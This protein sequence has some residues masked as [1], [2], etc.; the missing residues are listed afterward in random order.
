[1]MRKQHWARFWICTSMSVLCLAWMFSQAASLQALDE[2]GV[3]SPPNQ[4]P[5]EAALDQPPPNL[6]QPEVLTKGPLHEAFAA[7][8][9]LDTE[10]RPKV[11]RRPPPNVEEI[12]PE[13]KP[14]GDNVVWVPGYWGW[15][16]DR[17]DYV[18]VSGCWRAIP[19]GRKWVAGYWHQLSDGQ[20]QWVSGYWANLNQQQTEYLPAPPESLEMGPNIAAP[21]DEQFWVP[22]CWVYRNSRYLWRPGYWTG[23]QAGWVWNPA[24]YVW[25]PA[26]YIYVDGFWD[27]S[28][29]RRG[30]A[31]APCYFGGWSWG[32]GAWGWRFGLGLSYQ[33]WVCLDSD[34][35]TDSLFCRIGFGGYYFGDY[36][37]LRWWNYGYRP[38]FGCYGYRLYCPLYNYHQCFYQNRNPQWRN[39]LRQTYDRRI[40]HPENR[41]PTTFRDQQ[42]RNRDLTRPTSAKLEPQQSRQLPTA[43]PDVAKPV[44]RFVKQNEAAKDSVQSFQKLDRQR[45]QEFVKHSRGLDSTVNERRNIERGLSQQRQVD[46]PKGNNPPPAPKVLTAATPKSTFVG[47]P[48]NL[49]TPSVELPHRSPTI[50]RSERVL[51][52]GNAGPGSGMRVSQTPPPVAAP[53]TSRTF[54][55]TTPNNQPLDM[56]RSMQRLPASGSSPTIQRFPSQGSSMP[57]Q[58]FPTS[59]GFGGGQGYIPRSGF[60]PPPSSGRGFP[61]SGGFQ[62][63]GFNPPSG[64][65]PTPPPSRGGG[66]PGR[67]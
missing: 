36:Y 27:Y 28:L 7:P 15:D 42:R 12:P 21:D 66:R 32:L 62:Q 9:P 67:G 50:N 20:Y 65:A 31:F 58:R 51:S 18:W 63:R 60:Q 56:T 13:Q 14:A 44:N 10:E 29:R 54:R 47:K 46:L 38:W 43:N 61:S 6:I 40:D 64:P 8:T 23:W 19:P 34:Y 16:L 53:S 35:L 2:V 24:Y 39:D 4:K 41:P 11:D 37:G 17:K 52:G 55:P 57:S 22:G 48:I 3:N 30:L 5:N 45:T 59:G 49:P 25:S 26:G 33:P 1:M